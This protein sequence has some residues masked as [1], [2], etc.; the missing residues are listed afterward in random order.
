[1]YKKNMYGTN[2]PFVTLNNVNYGLKRDVHITNLHRYILMCQRMLNAE[3]F[4][5]K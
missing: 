4:N 3:L 2:I 1:M 5:I